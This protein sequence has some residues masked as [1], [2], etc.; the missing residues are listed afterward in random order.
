MA[1][2]SYKKD[3]GS[4]YVRE[5]IEVVVDKF[6]AGRTT[7]V[8]NGTENSSPWVSGGKW[9]LNFDDVF[10]DTN[11]TVT[12]SISMTN[13]SRLNSSGFSLGPIK[14]TASGVSGVILLNG[15]NIKAGETLTI[16]VIA[17][18]D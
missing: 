13:P 16:E 7:Y 11:Y 18:H 1:N 17:I 12:A 3:V 14:K 2:F 5:D 8:V 4:P 6:F 10:E 9:S 15:G